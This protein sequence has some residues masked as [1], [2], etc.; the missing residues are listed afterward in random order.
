MTPN[1]LVISGHDPSGGAG[2]VADIQTISACGAHPTLAIS[3][4]TEQD[5]ANAYAVFPV[6]ADQLLAQLDRVVADIPPQAIK[7]GLLPS[8]ASAQALL[9]LLDR[10]QDVPVV[11]DPVLVASGGGSLAEAD[12][13]PVLRDALIPRATV[14]TPNTLEAL[15]LTGQD[16]PA[17]AGHALVALGARWALVTGGDAPTHDVCNHLIGAETVTT[18]WP[19]RAGS[20]HG[21]GCTLA[22]ALAAGLALGRSVPEAALGAQQFVDRALAS[23]LRPGQGQ[24]IPRRFR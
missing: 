16:D 19:R 13:V 2:L 15:A 24:S 3:A 10:L 11:L 18:R 17:T 20:F 8:P 1:V 4:I 5:T 12:L 7:I 21:T 22:S 23:A 9:P 6:P 14:V